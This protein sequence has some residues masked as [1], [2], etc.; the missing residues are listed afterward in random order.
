[1]HTQM[2]MQG[3]E[4]RDADAGH[5][6]MESEARGASTAGAGCIDVRPPV[7]G[8]REPMRASRDRGGTSTE[9]KTAAN[10]RWATE[11]NKKSKKSK[12]GK[13][14][15]GK[16]AGRVSSSIVRGALFGRAGERA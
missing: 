13:D 11:Q 16:K 1:M 10:M 5:I 7:T 9:S 8:E 3:T 2:Q 4:D 12:K 6:E 15:K 14:R